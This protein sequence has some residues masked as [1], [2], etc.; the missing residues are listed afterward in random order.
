MS[1]VASHA[2]W[3]PYL[4]QFLESGIKI[5]VKTFSN[6]QNKAT[7][8]LIKCQERICDRDKRILVANNVGIWNIQL[9]PRRE[10]VYHR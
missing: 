1:W 3:L 2:M 5:T 6:P 10:I 9:I 8:H 7:S 4:E